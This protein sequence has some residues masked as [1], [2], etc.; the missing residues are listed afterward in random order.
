MIRSFA[1][2]ASTVT[3]RIYHTLGYL[4][5]LEADTNYVASLWLSLLG[6]AAATELILNRKQIAAFLFQTKPQTDP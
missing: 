1:L 4:A 2:T 5:G 3:F 6:N